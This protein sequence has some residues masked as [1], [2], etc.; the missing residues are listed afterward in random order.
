MVLQKQT[1]WLSSPLLIIDEKLWKSKWPANYCYFGEAVSNNIFFSWAWIL[2][3]LHLIFS[4]WLLELYLLPAFMDWCF[5][6]ITKKFLDSLS[7]IWRRIQR[8]IGK[9][10][11]IMVRI[12]RCLLQTLWM[13]WVW[14]QSG[15]CGCQP[16]CITTFGKIFMN[17]KHSFLLC[18]TTLQCYCGTLPSNFTILLY[19]GALLLY[20]M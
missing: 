10:S 8:P 5:H 12:I 6:K 17:I 4:L 14:D 2:Q 16:S 7:K 1:A 13:W 11:G 15:H 3:F 19:Q 9:G 20:E 18:L